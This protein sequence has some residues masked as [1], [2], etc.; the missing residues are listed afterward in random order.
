M[1]KRITVLFVVLLA[2]TSI[3]SCSSSDKPSRA[4]YRAGIKRAISAASNGDVGPYAGEK[5]LLDCAVQNTYEKLSPDAVKFVTTVKFDEDTIEKAKNQGLEDDFRKVQ[6]ELTQCYTKYVVDPQKKSNY[7]AAL[8]AAIS[9]V[10]SAEA[11]SGLSDLSGVTID[12]LTEQATDLEFVSAPLTTDAKRDKVGVISPTAMQVVL[13]TRE[14]LLGLCF[15]VELN[16]DSAT[17]Y[18]SSIVGPKNECGL[19]PDPKTGSDYTVDQQS[20]WS[21]KADK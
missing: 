14:P 8:R 10:R 21:T 19:A 12:T 7:K 6:D 18:G 1:I 5:Q 3:V 16:A 4:E 2:A 17:R 15:F 20:G 9:T 13:Q 11:E